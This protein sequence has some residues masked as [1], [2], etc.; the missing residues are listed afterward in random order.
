MLL[1][2][3]MLLYSVVL[4]VL[5]CSA[6]VGSVVAASGWSQ[7]YGGTLS[8]YACSLIATSDG[9]YALTGGSLLV[10][11]DELGN[12]QWNKTYVDGSINSL[13]TASDGGYA[14]A[15]STSSFGAGYEDFWLV[16]T[17]ESGVYPEYSS[18]LVPALVLTATV[19]IIINKKQLLNKRSQAS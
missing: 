3:K 12:A 14:S 2:R 18:W 4:F 19:F 16:K 15:G 6:S 17:D 5:L 11:T 7:A 9:G 8:D 1:R 13:V 10:K